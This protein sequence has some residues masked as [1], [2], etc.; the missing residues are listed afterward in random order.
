MSK[1]YKELK[2]ILK[3]LAKE[4]R[5]NKESLKNYQ[6]KNYGDGGNYYRTLYTYQYEFRHK[7]I[8]YC[9]LRGTPRDKIEKPGEGNEPSE[10]FIKEII[11]EYSSETAQTTE[12]VCSSS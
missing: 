12:N 5:K 7:H 2:I 11:E 9:V 1:K 8:A 4:I 6:R 3:N 10:N